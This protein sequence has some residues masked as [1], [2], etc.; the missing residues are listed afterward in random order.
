MP[1]STSAERFSNSIGQHHPEKSNCRPDGRRAEDRAQEWPQIGHAQSARQRTETQDL[2][3][4]SVRRS[5]RGD[6]LQTPAFN[7]LNSAVLLADYDV[8]KQ[9]LLRSRSVR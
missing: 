3:T 9:H 2:R 1:Q 8:Q 5:G 7:E 4:Q 6:S